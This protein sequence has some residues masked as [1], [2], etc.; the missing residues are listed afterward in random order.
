MLV[1]CAMSLKLLRNL[2]EIFKKFPSKCFPLAERRLAVARGPSFR[3]TKSAPSQGPVLAG[4]ECGIP[5][6]PEADT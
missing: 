5:G 6:F 2:L 1:F 4:I 3:A